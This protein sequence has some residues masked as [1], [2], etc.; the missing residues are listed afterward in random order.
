MQLGPKIFGVDLIFGWYTSVIFQFIIGSWHD[1][2]LKICLPLREGEVFLFYQFLL[3]M[4]VLV[5]L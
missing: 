1:K 4:Q 5:I 2:H 3:K